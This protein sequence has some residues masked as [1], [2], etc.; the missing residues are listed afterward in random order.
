MVDLEPTAIGEVIGKAMADVR[1]LT[2]EV[3]AAK[4]RRVEAA[5]EEGRLDTS[6]RNSRAELTR[7]LAKGDLIDFTELERTDAYRRRA[8]TMPD[9]QLVGPT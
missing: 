9:S 6:L 5:S 8:K 2:V 1:R 4:A 7:L 3:A